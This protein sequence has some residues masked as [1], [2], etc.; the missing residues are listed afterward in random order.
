MDNKRFDDLARAWAGGISRRQLLRGIG[1]LVLAEVLG[2]FPGLSSLLLPSRTAKAAL[3]Q[4]DE[5]TAYLPLVQAAS[6][7]TLSVLNTSQTQT[8]M[9]QAQA[10]STYA[11]LDQYLRS[12][13]FVR[14]DETIAASIQSHLGKTAGLVSVYQ[15]S[16]IPNHEAHLFFVEDP[17]VGQ[18]LAALAAQPTG[19]SAAQSAAGATISQNK[20]LVGYV[21]AEDNGIPKSTLR[22]EKFNSAKAV[23]EGF[24]SV[25]TAISTPG[26]G[27]CELLASLVCYYYYPG[28]LNCPSIAAAICEGAGALCEAKGCDDVG[29]KVCPDRFYRDCGEDCVWFECSCDGVPKICRANP[30]EPNFDGTVCADLLSDP[31]HCGSCDNNC[32]QHEHVTAAICVNGQCQATACED[33]YLVKDGMCIPDICR[34]ASC[35]DGR[36]CCPGSDGR[37]YS[38]CS[39]GWVC[40]GSG[41]GPATGCCPPDSQCC[42]NGEGEMGCCPAEMICTPNGC[43]LDPNTA[44]SEGFV[45]CGPPQNQCCRKGGV[46]CSNYDQCCAPDVGSVTSWCITEYRGCVASASP[47]CDNCPWPVERPRRIAGEGE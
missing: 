31:G 47:N 40:C 37:T 11:T 10:D 13:G 2:L 16:T 8:V 41:T 44:C 28:K 27:G 19:P 32:L 42:P 14:N 30:D 5:N 20:M 29:R 1:G 17:T 12:E 45:F 34:E 36:Y 46:C 3:S 6:P 4:T 43:E 22:R 33:G 38:C 15:H 39:D 18:G 25:A 7:P 24:C 26:G 21:R 23:C 35:P 9:T